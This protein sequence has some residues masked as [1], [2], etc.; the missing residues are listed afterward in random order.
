MQTGIC[1]C[2]GFNN[3]NLQIS[4]Q[5]WKNRLIINHQALLMLFKGQTKKSLFNQTARTNNI[6]L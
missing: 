4:K 6:Y 2:N 1:E 5:L 3:N